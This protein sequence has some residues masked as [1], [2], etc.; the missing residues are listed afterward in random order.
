VSLPAILPALLLGV[1]PLLAGCA[2]KQPTAPEL[3]ELYCARC[4]GEGGRGDARSLNLYPNLDLLRSQMVR[5]GDRGIVRRRIA[6][7]YGPMPGF[8]HRLSGEEIEGLV[9]FTLQLQAEKAGE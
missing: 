3:Y 1:L 2:R 9:D 7:G 8:S 6:E 4:H 5:Q